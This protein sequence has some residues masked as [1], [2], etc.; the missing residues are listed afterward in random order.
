M[1]PETIKAC[2]ADLYASDVVR[3]LFGD[4][5]HPGGLALTER[6]GVLLGLDSSS[7][8][9]D[10]AAGRGTSA[11]YLARRFG[12]RVIGLDYS[13][14]NLMQ[15]TE[16]A[17][18]NGLA[19]RVEFVQGD[20]EQLSALASESFDAVLCEC[21]Y[22]TF[23]NKQRA[24]AE[25]ARVLAPAGRF[26]LSDLTRNGALPPELDGLMSWIACIADARPVAS[27]IADLEAVG[28]KVRHI[29]AHDEALTE[30]I[31]EVRG[32]LM[33]AEIVT[34]IQQV[35]LPRGVDMKLAK[36]VARSALEAVK[37]RTLGYTLIIASRHGA[38]R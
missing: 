32:R 17:E 13:S 36:R 23:P 16:A 9:L 38:L 28:L 4:S 6:L 3:L 12:C 33:A 24:A 18:R 1:T 27:Y 8:V 22:C 25:V 2:C 15:A 20:A 10:L 35:E 29:E 31:D 37:A 7:H 26:G 30:L 21:A 14:V 34:K 5:L 11:L 19:E